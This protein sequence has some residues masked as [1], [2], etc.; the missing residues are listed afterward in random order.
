L[1]AQ[2][3]AT[4]TDMQVFNDLGGQ[5]GSDTSTSGGRPHVAP[6]LHGSLPAPFP[7]SAV[8]SEAKRG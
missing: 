8:V 1:D 5:P 2:P 6:R 4:L 7:P 3:W